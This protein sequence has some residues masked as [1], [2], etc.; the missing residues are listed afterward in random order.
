MWS[1]ILSDL[2]PKSYPQQSQQLVEPIAGSRTHNYEMFH[3]LAKLGPSGDCTPM[4]PAAAIGEGRARGSPRFDRWR[5]G[6]MLFGAVQPTRWVGEQHVREDLGR[7]PSIARLGPVH[8]ARTLGGR[9]TT[10][11]VKDDPRQPHARDVKTR[12]NSLGRNTARP[13]R[14]TTAARLDSQTASCHDIPTSGQLGA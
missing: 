10:L 5:R 9:A 1:F 11:A 8:S 7:I 3:C 4:R 14:T 13:P 12:I 6:E 2:P